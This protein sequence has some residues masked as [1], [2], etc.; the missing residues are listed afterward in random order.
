MSDR[1]LD[2]YQQARED[3]RRAFVNTRTLREVS[4][5]V[6]QVTVE[7][8]FVDQSR[9]EDYSPQT[10]TFHPAATAFFEFPC[11]AAECT[12]GGFD[13]MRP[14]SLLIARGGQEASGTLDCVGQQSADRHDGHR[15]LLQMH[16][17][18]T[19]SYKS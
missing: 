10:H 4:P 7:L 18:V 1:P 11:P 8:S 14:V 15:A 13:L 12:G 9:T 6:E 5:H 2:R 17:R 3:R 19:V 16:Y